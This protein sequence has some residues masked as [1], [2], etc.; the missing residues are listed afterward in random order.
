M[1]GAHYAL[2]SLDSTLLIPLY[3]PLLATGFA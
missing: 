2:M 3:L 1:P